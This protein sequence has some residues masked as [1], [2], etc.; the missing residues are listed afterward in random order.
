MNGFENQ[1]VRPLTARESVFIEF[2][3]SQARHYSGL[4][5]ESTREHD[6][7]LQSEQVWPA[8]RQDATADRRRAGL[9]CVTRR[10]NGA[11]PTSA[12]TSRRLSCPNAGTCARGNMAVHAPTRLIAVNFSDLLELSRCIERS[13]QIGPIWC[14]LYSR[15]F[16]R[17][18]GALSTRI[19]ELHDSQRIHRN[20][21]HRGVAN[22]LDS[23]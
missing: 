21:R 16:R 7:E 13:K 11:T 9:D 12:T 2:Q 4:T 15:S 1:L 20:G 17:T 23:S 5:R 8:Y 18:V 14:L 3:T 19:G 22:G 6:Q 10:L